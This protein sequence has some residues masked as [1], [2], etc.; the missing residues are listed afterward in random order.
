MEKNI[1]KTNG[2]TN[3]P[4]YEDLKS[5]VNE[6]MMENRNLRQKLNQVMSIQNKIPCLFEILKNKDFF[7]KEYLDA[8]VDEIKII[9]PPYK[10]ETVNTDK[11]ED[12]EDTI[13][14]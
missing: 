14:K 6:L 3:K 8:V 4:S 13:N 5:Y 2:K 1:N 7:D 10:E 9:I 11:K 12:K